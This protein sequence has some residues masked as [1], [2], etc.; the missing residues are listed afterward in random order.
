[1]VLNVVPIQAQTAPAAAGS[2]NDRTL[3]EGGIDTGTD[4]VG[5]TPEPLPKITITATRDTIF[6]SLEDMRFVLKR[7]NPGEEL[8]VKL[9]LHQDENWLTRSTRSYGRC[10][11]RHQRKGVLGRVDRDIG[12]GL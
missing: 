5:V 9:W 10:Q 4:A 8:T 2:G 7:E 1:M 6:G 3:A 12:R 11:D